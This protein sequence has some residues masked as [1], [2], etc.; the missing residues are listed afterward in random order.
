MKLP[1]QILPRTRARLLD[2]EDANPKLVFCHSR[3]V[4]RR[5]NE[6]ILPQRSM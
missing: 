2:A 1:A 5:Y 6:L 3:F 4:Y